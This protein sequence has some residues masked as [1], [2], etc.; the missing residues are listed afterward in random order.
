MK[1]GGFPISDRLMD[2]LADR[3][4]LGLSPQ[5]EAELASLLRDV[6]GLDAECMD[7]AAAAADV[8][9]TARSTPSSNAGSMPATLRAKIAAEGRAFVTEAAARA[10]RP[11]PEERPA[12]VGRIRPAPDRMIPGAGPSFASL[13]WLAAAACLA[14]AGVAW[15]SD[16]GASTGYDPA[17]AK[18]RL[19]ASATDLTRWDWAALGELDGRTI[20]GEAVWSS[21]AQRGYMSF[22]GL[23][24]NDPSREQYQLWIFDPSQSDKTPIDGGVFNIPATAAA[25][26]EIVVPIDPKLRPTGP[27]MFAITVEKPG[28]VV[29][30][31]RKRLV[32]IA[33]PA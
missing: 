3:A 19:V 30:S 10:A 9:L 15:F 2:L 18:S 7:R 11:A 29:V 31:D 23:A 6:P 14:L 26:A 25:G 4:V 1:S 20:R 12:V 24:P 22:A 28:G 27:V 32:L 17:S 16:R 13:G 33:K 21:A 8:A 5:D